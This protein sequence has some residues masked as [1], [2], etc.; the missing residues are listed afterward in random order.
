MKQE[1]FLTV[2][3]SGIEIYFERYSGAKE[4]INNAKS[5]FR[6]MPSRHTMQR[7]VWQAAFL[8]SN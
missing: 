2:K 7:M 8:S 6:C 3:N 4:N 1:A 5:V